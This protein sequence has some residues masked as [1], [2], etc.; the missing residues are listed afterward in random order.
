[1]KKYKM[2]FKTTTTTTTTITTT[3]T[4]TTTTRTT[5]IA[6]ATTTTTTKEKD[7]IHKW[8]KGTLIKKVCLRMSCF[9]PRYDYL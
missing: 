5:T 9:P 8:L 7:H 4:A 2:Q 3:I 6:A 1:M